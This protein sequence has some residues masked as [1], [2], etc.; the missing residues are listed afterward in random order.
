MKIALA[1]GLS[2]AL[3]PTLV[4]QHGTVVATTLDQLRKSPEAY[5][6]VWVRFTVQFAS[7]GKVQNPFFTE[8]ES[9]KFANFYG[10][11]DEQAIWKKGQYE[12]LFGLL[13][14]AKN[15]D[16]CSKIY[17]MKVYDRIEV[18]A[19]VR[20]VFQHQPWLEITE[21]TKLKHRVNT[22][23]LSHLYRGESYMQKRDWRR[24][25]AELSLAPGKNIPDHIRG[26]VHKN[27]AMCYLRLGE[28]GTAVEHLEK[29]VDLMHD[30]DP[31]I[32][33]MAALA[34][35][36]PETFLD[37]TLSNAQV[38]EHHRPIWEAFEKVTSTADDE[39][40][41]EAETPAEQPT[42]AKQPTPA[43]QPGP[44]AGK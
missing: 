14:V 38:E 36:K 28:A 30:I 35:V 42:P 37:R 41:A 29:A 32:R 3:A 43:E 12:D 9:S 39:D 20:N 8:F 10:W 18:V 23:T 11:A 31:E 24:A 21:F 22:A 40:E 15:N 27:L 4:A 1:L 44:T 17:K 26:Q 19:I 13:F 2:L 33:Q 7:L 16:I 25:L 34:K 6:G 5:R